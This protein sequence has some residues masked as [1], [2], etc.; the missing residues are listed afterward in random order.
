MQH[1]RIPGFLRKDFGRKDM[2]LGKPYLNPI[3]SRYWENGKYV[4][5][6]YNLFLYKYKLLYCELKQW[7]IN[8]WMRKGIDHFYNGNIGDLLI[9][10]LGFL[11]YIYWIANVSLLEKNKT[12][13]TLSTNFRTDNLNIIIFLGH[14]KSCVWASH[15]INLRHSFFLLWQNTWHWLWPF[16]FYVKPF[17]WA[18]LS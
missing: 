16:V 17:D 1:I 9:S 7:F 2:S 10:H 4:I 15:G 14:N 3:P 6:T 5:L 12:K 11:N 8:G 18:V 13:N